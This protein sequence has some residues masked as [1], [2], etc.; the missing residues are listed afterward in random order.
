MISNSNTILITTTIHKNKNC[1]I[2]KKRNIN[3]IKSMSKYNIPIYF[4]IGVENI[5]KNDIMFNNLK[6]MFEF[7]ITSNYNYGIICDNDFHPHSN[8]LEELN[9]TVNLLPENWRCLHLCPGFLLG[10]NNKNCLDGRL[11]PENNIK[12]LEYDVSGRFFINCNN[13]KFVKKNIW[14]GGPIA[15]LINKNNIN[16][17]L[18]DYINF[19]NLYKKPNDVILTY[20][21]NKNDYVCR[22]PLLGYENEQGG[23][24]FK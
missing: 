18:Q 15:I 14:L 4:N 24:C 19:Y 21:L 10:R 22:Y 12:D 23:S 7:F 3:L 11:N 2:S 1:K 8:L 6:N 20:I 13:G 17:L 9:K 5:P 16:E